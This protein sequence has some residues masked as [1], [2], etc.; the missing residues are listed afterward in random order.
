MHTHFV[1]DDC[2]KTPVFEFCSGHV[3]SWFVL[4]DA[5]IFSIVRL[6]SQKIRF[7][8][9]CFR[10]RISQIGL[11]LQHLR[12]AY[13]PTSIPYFQASYGIEIRS[14]SKSCQIPTPRL[15]CLKGLCALE[16]ALTMN[17]VQSGC[18]EKSVQS[19]I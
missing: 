19:G 17:G 1:T 7:V 11:Q 2:Y 14:K 12:L 3:R 10:P 13:W 4:V 6:Q 18:S 9:L 15:G 8:T 16:T 5:W